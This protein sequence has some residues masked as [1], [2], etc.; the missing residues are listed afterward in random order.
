MKYLPTRI[1]WLLF[2]PLGL[3]AQGTPSA[4]LRTLNEAIAQ[5][6]RYDAVKRQRI[7]AL[8]TTLARTPAAA[9]QERF[10][11]CG[12]LYDEYKVFNYDSAYR[13]ARTLQTLATQLQDP[14]RVTFARIK[15]SF[16]LLS[17]GM[18]KETYDSLSLV[19]IDDAPDSLR[20]EYYTLLARYYYDLAD[21][22]NDTYH[23]PGYTRLANRY[24][25]S[26]L[27]LYDA[28][29]F[30]Y[31]YFNGLKYIRSGN[32]DSA[33][34]SFQQII[35]NP[36]LSTHQYAVT[37]STLS[38]IYIQRGQVDTAISLLIEAAIADIKTSTKETAAL[39]NLATLLY[40]KDDVKHAAAYIEQAIRD[41]MFYGARQRKVQMSA[42]LPL[43]E[44]EKVNRVES[45]QKLLFIY[46]A[47]VT[48]LLLVV[49]WLAV[50]IFRQFNKLKHA[51]R[52]ITESA[53]R[54]REINAKL[55][56]ANRIKEEYIGYFFNV[57][58]V[59][60]NKMERFKKSLDQKVSDRKLEEI[61]F[62]V[63]NINLKQEKED[64]LRDFDKVFLKLFPN[65][66]QDYNG[67][68]ESADQVKLKDQELLNTD[69]R[70]FALIRMGI[71]DNEKIAQIL[72]YSV[73]T[74]NTYKTRIKNKS[75][76]PNE[77]FEHH[78]MEIKAE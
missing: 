49:V 63:N 28:K 11:V 53:T 4:T 37:A 8:Q 24:V 48:S 31:A 61:R 43:I 59:F 41:A 67:L 75:K 58:S 1:L 77:A 44:S 25:D 27:Q 56:E 14:A 5:A 68:F 45:Q 76:V 7:Q 71:H 6:P 13:Y 33:L 46:S 23:T 50:V 35:N 20:A 47:I 73:N 29:S 26:A 62:L 2:L 39:F 52:L 36:M 40:K 69:L 72:E 38:D 54:Q 9:L 42:I 18:F 66:V 10:A 30:Q 57:N 17:S 22:D 3:L 21:F 32:M 70:I 55:E 74:I 60:F 65:F 78:I 15:L 51:Q 34:T 19:H 12:Q 64:L 16:I